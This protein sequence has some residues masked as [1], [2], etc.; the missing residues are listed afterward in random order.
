MS[1]C[2]AR[3]GQEMGRL[4]HGTAACC[5]LPMDEKRNGTTNTKQND[6]GERG[7]YANMYDT[8]ERSDVFTPVCRM[9]VTGCPR[10]RV[11][12]NGFCVRADLYSTVYTLHTLNGIW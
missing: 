6:H 5:L 9:N 8:Y 2:I 12:T 11:Y 7:K 10:V 3:A 4:S 1:V